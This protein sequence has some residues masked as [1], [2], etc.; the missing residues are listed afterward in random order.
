MFWQRKKM[1][2]PV[3]HYKN[4]EFYIF[5]ITTLLKI[6]RCLQ[7]QLIFA[8]CYLMFAIFMDYIRLVGH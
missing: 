7:G 2:T 8:I 4:C 1:P 3:F 5:H 6:N